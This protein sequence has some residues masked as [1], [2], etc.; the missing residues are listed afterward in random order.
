MKLYGRARFQFYENVEIFIEISTGISTQ[1]IWKILLNL[2][3]VYSGS[4]EREVENHADL[5]IKSWSVKIIGGSMGT[6]PRQ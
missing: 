4:V 2:S 6:I 5:V 1:L 3:D